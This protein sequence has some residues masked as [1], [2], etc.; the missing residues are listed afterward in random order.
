MSKQLF[1]QHDKYHIHKVLGF[2]CLFHYFIRLYYIIMHGTMFFDCNSTLTTITP[3]VHLFLSVSSFIF[4]VPKLRYDSKII[5]WK[6][7]QLHNIIFTSRSAM[8][9]IYWLIFRV[10]EN[11]DFNKYYRLHFIMR[12]LIVMVHHLL[13][14]KITLVYHYNNKTTTRDMNDDNISIYVKKYYAVCQILAINAIIL[15]ESDVSGK[16][17]IEAS[18]II[19]FPIQL[20][21]FLMTLVRKSII[22]NN[23]F[24]ILYGLSLAT[25]FLITINNKKINNISIKTILSMIYYISRLYFRYNKYYLMIFVV[26]TYLGHQYLEQNLS[27]ELTILF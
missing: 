24:H 9:M 2:S 23:F 26:L 10:Y 4:H 27:K 16:G 15:G 3:F 20:S 7:L 1:T 18:F 13:A 17:F 14:D 11:S 22:S 12:L 8:T 5:I 6:E 25:P 21:T 19:M